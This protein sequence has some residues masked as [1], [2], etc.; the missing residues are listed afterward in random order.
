MCVP[1]ISRCTI[2]YELGVCSYNERMKRLFVGVA[3]IVGIILIA[4]VIGFGLSKKAG[5][6]YGRTTGIPSVSMIEKSVASSSAQLPQVATASALTPSPTPGI[7]L[8]PIAPNERTARVPILLYHYMSENPNK[9]D[10]ARDGLF[11]PPS[12]FK[13]QLETLKSAGYTTITFDE[14]AA[15]FDGKS[16]L[17]SKPVIL[18]FDDGYRDF[19]LN[20]YPIL[21]SS[22]MKGIAFISTGLIG[23]GAYMTWSQ[24]EEIARSPFVVVGAHSVHHYVLT[25]SNPNILKNELEE[26]KKILE[27]HA[28]YPVNWMALSLWF[29]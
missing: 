19:Y 17:P 27:A 14:L 24:V 13:S 4:V 22:G 11:T 20:A 23:G 2:L 3:G 21:V 10:I 7:V 6:F 29:V 28:R 26:S 9:D 12:I 18:T 15:F 5:N 25:K 16:S 8:P 1:I